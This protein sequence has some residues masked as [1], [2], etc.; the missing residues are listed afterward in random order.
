VQITVLIDTSQPLI[1]CLNMDRP[2]SKKKAW[3]VT[4]IL[5]RQRVL[6]VEPAAQSLSKRVGDTGG[7]QGFAASA[8]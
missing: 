2:I 4:D 3:V 5:R 1:T 6:G 7:A 8:V